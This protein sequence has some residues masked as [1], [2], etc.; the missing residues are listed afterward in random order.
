MSLGMQSQ[1]KKLLETDGIAES[2]NYRF[3]RKKINE[4]AL[5]DVY[6]GMLYKKWSAP[7]QPLS[8]PD[9]ISLSW[10]TDGIPLGKSSHQQIY[11]MYVMINEL[12]PKLRVKNMLMVGI[13]VRKKNLTWK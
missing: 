8:N 3:I 12:P 5:E 6:D 11:P 1:L 10:N 4:S 7:G 2:L 13:W 9:N